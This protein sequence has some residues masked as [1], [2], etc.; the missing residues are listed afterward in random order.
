[1]EPRTVITENWLTRKPSPAALPVTLLLSS[2]LFAISY[3]FL[4]AN[5]TVNGQSLDQLIIA[6]KH[7]VFDQHQYWRAWTTLFAHADAG[8]LMSNAFLFIPL[9]YILFGY[10]GSFVFPVA[11]LL[12]GGV[13]NLI[14]L[15]T[16]P[17]ATSLLGISG[18][19]Y[20]MGATWLT[21]FIFIDRRKKLRYRLAIALF[22]S[23]VLFVPDKYQPQISYLSHLLGFFA[24]V[25]F[26]AIYYGIR[27]K[28]ILAAEKIELIYDTEETALPQELNDQRAL[29]K[30]DEL[31]QIN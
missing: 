2:L 26:G 9:T 12:I 18:V 5:F 28:Q 14:V 29:P 15:K 27:R 23:L 31:R 6:S 30:S 13:V 21:F 16:M 1:M 17:D 11:G 25:I 4:A 7:L 22:L 24:G 8:H 20:W 10:F 3:L 19:V